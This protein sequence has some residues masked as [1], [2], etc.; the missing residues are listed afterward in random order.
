MELSDLKGIGPARINALH[1]MGIFSLRDLLYYM[2]GRYEDHKTLYPCSAALEGPVLVEGILEEDP[3]IS[4]FGGLTKI[5]GR[6]RDSSGILPVAWY[7]EPWLSRWLHAGDRLCLYGK[8]TIRDH[9]RILQNPKIIKEKGLFPVYRL[10]AGMTSGVYR[11]IVKQAFHSV[12]TNLSETLPESLLSRYHLCGLKEALR[13][14]HFP[15]DMNSIAEARRRISFEKALMYMTYVSIAGVERKP[16][17]VITADAASLNTYWNSLDFSPTGAQIRS[18]EEIAGD[19]GKPYAMRRLVQGDV[20]CGKTAVA[21]GSLYLAY[22]KGFQSCMMAPTEILARQHYQEALKT[23][24][25]MGIHCELLTGHTSVKERKSICMKMENGESNVL[26]GTHALLNDKIRY[27]RLGLVITDEQHRFGVNQRSKLQ[28]ENDDGLSPHMLV[29][30]ATPIP[31]S[32]ALILYGDLDLSVID[33]M[34]AGRK[35]VQTRIVPENRRED[36]YRFLVD[37]T[38]HGKQAYIVCPLVDDSESMEEL[39]SAMHLFTDLKKN[40][41]KNVEAGLTWGNQDNAEKASVL[42]S[43]MN[44]KISVL[45]STTVIEVGINNPNAC[46]MVI[47]NAERFGLSQLHQLRGRVGRGKDESW[48]FLVTDHREKLDILAKTNDGFEIARKDLEMR[49]PGDLMG[50]RQSGMMNILDTDNNI[51]LLNDV[52]HAVRELM[53]HAEDPS[54]AAVIRMAADYFSERGKQIAVH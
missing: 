42:Q 5:T 30:S 15:D 29:M 17:P 14:I 18:L 44:K 48:C 10:S 23:L 47:E 12:E 19:I 28:K 11:T 39:K 36:M 34:P 51:A 27:Q 4:H 22:L 49:G 31:R 33:E 37:Q 7:H 2:P 8:I 40:V 35:P 32:L 25:P 53:Q 6:L 54:A 20:G 45:V 26:F 13:Q 43:F 21:F 16:A 1:A 9:R 52:S 50:I 24:S 46:I 41:L 3:R 38:V